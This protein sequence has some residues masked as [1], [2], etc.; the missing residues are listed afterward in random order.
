MVIFNWIDFYLFQDSI[1]MSLSLLYFVFIYYNVIGKLY[2]NLYLILQQEIL[3]LF[4]LD[5]ELIYYVIKV[6]DFLFMMLFLRI[7]LDKVIV[8]LFLFL[9]KRSININN[10]NFVRRLFFLWSKKWVDDIVVKCNNQRIFIYVLQGY[11]MFCWF[12][13]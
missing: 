8:I 12:G 6:S 9:E 10:V 4:F 13:N 7:F 3:Y 2:M 11:E 1:F 5:D